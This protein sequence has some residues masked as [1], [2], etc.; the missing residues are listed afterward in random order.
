MPASPEYVEQFR[1]NGVAIP[2]GILTA[3][4]LQPVIDE[5]SAEID[6]RANKLKDEGK[7]DDLHADRPFER[8]LADLYAQCPEITQGLDIMHYRGRA[9]FEFFHN[10]NLLDALEPLIGGEITCNPIQHLRFKMP[11]SVK[12]DTQGYE[13]SVPWH[14]DAAVTWEEADHTDIITVWIPLVDAT[15]QTGCMEVIPGVF[16][17]GYLEHIAEGGTQIKP[18]AMPDR[19]PITA[20]VRKGGAVLMSRYTPHRSTPNVSETV[21]WSLDLRFQKTGLPTGRPFHPDFV[22]R[23]RED[24]SSVLDDHDTW[25][26]LWIDAMENS[27]GVAAHRTQK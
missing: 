5:I 4:D 26:K 15:K 14:Q 9:I 17:G 18:E 7:I 27:K 24:P 6:R 13:G 22:V 11:T 1:R 21:R 10:Q 19:D 23:S 16:E 3:A 12:Q 8:R 25:C 20:E 2:E